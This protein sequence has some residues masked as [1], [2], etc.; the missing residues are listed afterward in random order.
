[1]RIFEVEEGVVD[2]RDIT[3]PES[4][5]VTL[6]EEVTDILARGWSVREIAGHVK[7]ARSKV[8]RIRNRIRNR[9]RVGDSWDLF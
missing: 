4:R 9:A 8:R 5:S 2:G 7:M 3:A 1:M 6:F